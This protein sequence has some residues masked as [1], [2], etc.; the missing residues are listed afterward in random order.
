[1]EVTMIIFFALQLPDEYYSL[2]A[3]HMTCIWQKHMWYAI[4]FDAD[5]NKFTMNRQIIKR[6][7][8]WIHRVDNHYPI[9]SNKISFTWLQGA[10][11][12][13]VHFPIPKN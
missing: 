1:M 2:N 9:D 11:L 5:E 6:F 13:A 10:V 8:R 3:L 7:N 4:N 12:S